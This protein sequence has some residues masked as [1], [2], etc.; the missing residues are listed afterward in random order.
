MKRQPCEVFARVCGYIRPV[1]QF[2]DS[3]QQETKDRVMFKEEYDT[4]AIS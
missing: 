3:K 4:R 1:S 2:N